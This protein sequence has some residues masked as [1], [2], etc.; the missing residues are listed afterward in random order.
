MR[1]SSWTRPSA[2][3]GTAVCPK[4]PFLW[5]SGSRC[6]TCGSHMRSPSSPMAGFGQ[7]AWQL[8][9]TTGAWCSR[10]QTVRAAT[11]RMRTTHR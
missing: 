6:R 4:A 7:P 5:H 1:S 8:L 2:A 10:V 9:V 3:A 11:A